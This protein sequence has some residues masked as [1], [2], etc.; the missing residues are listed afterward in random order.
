[1]AESRNL[2]TLRELAQA[3]GVSMPTLQRFE[4]ASPGR[5][6]SVGEGKARRYPQEA[7]AVVREMRQRTVEDDPSHAELQE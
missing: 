4:M 1:M 6:P 2:Y 3:F 7:I 5:I